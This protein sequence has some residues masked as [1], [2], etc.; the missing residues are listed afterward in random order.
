MANTRCEDTVLEY[1]YTASEVAKILG[2]SKGHAYKIIK[3]MNE[4][5]KKRGYI[6]QPGKIPKKYFEEKN[7]GMASK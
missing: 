2:I 4:D 1:Y 3:P 6:A 5:L 7:Y